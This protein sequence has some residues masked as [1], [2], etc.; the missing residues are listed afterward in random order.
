MFKQSPA[1]LK[2]KLLANNKKNITNVT[3]SPQDFHVNREI[4]SHTVQEATE[5]FETPEIDLMDDSIVYNR[6]DTSE[7]STSYNTEEDEDAYSNYLEDTK[8][9]YSNAP[10]DEQERLIELQV[11]SRNDIINVDNRLSS[12]YLRRYKHEDDN[13]ELIE[14]GRILFGLR[15]NG[16]T[17]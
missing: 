3:S 5:P 13:N 7:P 9:L 6:H 16:P 1:L 15:Y 10:E 17:N 4:V 8:S 14:K 12:I 2:K 11:A